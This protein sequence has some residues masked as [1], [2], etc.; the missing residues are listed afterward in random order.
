VDLGSGAGFPG[1]VV[2]AALP[3]AEVHLVESDQRKAEFLRHVS[4][5]TAT[6]VTVWGRRIADVAATGLKADVVTARAL[7]ALD[8]LLD[9]SDPFCHEDTVRLFPKG[10]SVEAELTRLDPSKTIRIA[11]LP[12]VTAASAAIVR[13]EGKRLG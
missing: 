8:Q 4:R 9:M 1:L 10:E 6:P 3:E 13:I 11:R 5:E 7:A 12:S 2:A